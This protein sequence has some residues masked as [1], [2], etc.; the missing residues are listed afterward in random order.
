MR[1]N[2]AL[3]LVPVTPVRMTNR[4]G[5]RYFDRKIADGKTRN[6]AM[7][8]LKR[9]IAGHLWRLMLADEQAH[10]RHIEELRT[11]A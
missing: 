1:L 7:R 5:R 3:H 4:H 6:E 11:A 10:H 9:R 2:S 8:C